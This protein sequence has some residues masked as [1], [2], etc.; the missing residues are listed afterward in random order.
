[1]ILS[2]MFIL[3][4]A[5]LARIGGLQLINDFYTRRK[6]AIPG[7]LSTIDEVINTWKGA[8]GNHKPRERRLWIRWKANLGRRCGDA[9]DR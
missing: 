6:Y 2:L 4:Q 3:L 7:E 1:M 9:S 8:I 5:L